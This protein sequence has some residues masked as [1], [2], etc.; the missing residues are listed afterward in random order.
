MIAQFRLA[1]TCSHGVVNILSC[2]D[3]VHRM[4]SYGASQHITAQHIKVLYIILHHSTTHHITLFHYS[5]SPHST[6]QHNISQRITSQHTAQHIQHTTPYDT[7]SH[8]TALHYYVNLSHRLQMH[9]LL[10]PMI[11][12]SQHI[13]PILACLCTTP[14]VLA[15]VAYLS[16]CN[17]VIYCIHIVQ[18]TS[19]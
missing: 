14:C 2:S 6:S 4:V 7:T 3:F 13:Q 19:Y 9:G 16:I 5:S 8:A 11:T 10:S 17:V 18:F 1:V 15:L 12:T